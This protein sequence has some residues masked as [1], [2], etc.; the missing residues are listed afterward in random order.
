VGVGVGVGVDF[1]HKLS[2][3]AIVVSAPLKET[4]G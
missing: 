1:R 2:I 3:C 4:K